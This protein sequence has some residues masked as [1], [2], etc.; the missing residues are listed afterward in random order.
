MAD[1]TIDE[2]TRGTPLGSYILPYS[3]GSNTLGVPVSALFQGGGSNIGIGLTNPNVTL[4][5]NGQ[6]SATGSIACNQNITINNSNYNK[7]NMGLV[8]YLGTQAIVAADINNWN[9]SLR[10]AGSQDLSYPNTVALYSNNNIR[11]FVA[12]NGNVKIGA[13]AAPQAKLDVDG[14]VK[15]SGRILL[16]NVTPQQGTEYSQIGQVFAEGVIN[17]NS[18]VTINLNAMSTWPCAGIFAIILQSQV[19]GLNSSY[20]NQK[21][22]T[23]RYGSFVRTLSKNIG[24]ST[25][26]AQDTT[27]LSVP[28]FTGLGIT[29]LTNNSSYACDYSIR[30]LPVLARVWPLA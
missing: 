21:A 11:M 27:L 29:T 28:D 6:L 2:L 9:N 20:P 8:N 23:V 15:V 25:I 30:V 22:S 17:A 16:S 7:T 24:V 5:I 1:V 14:D 4:T 3:T 12:A 19:I 10:I 18:S 26:Y 13:D